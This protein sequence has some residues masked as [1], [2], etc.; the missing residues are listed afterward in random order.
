M[1]KHTTEEQ[2][3][4]SKYHLEKDS[5]WIDCIDVEKF[6]KYITKFFL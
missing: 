4:F 1:T 5:H 3:N 6:L 2:W